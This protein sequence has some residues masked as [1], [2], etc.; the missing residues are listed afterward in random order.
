MKTLSPKRTSGETGVL[1]KLRCC[2][3]RQ[4][5]ETA[6][7]VLCACETLAVLRYRHLR[8]QLL[9]TRGLRGHLCQQD[10]ALCS[11]CGAAESVSKRTAQKTENVLS[12]RVIRPPTFTI[13]STPKATFSCSSDFSARRSFLF[14][15]RLCSVSPV[16]E[17][18]ISR[19]KCMRV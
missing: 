19:G 11:Q 8:Q 10:T 3:C 1:D 14:A 2:I 18:N 17:F 5:I 12:A 16:F 4:A 9:E 7:L 13:F 6:S 15:R